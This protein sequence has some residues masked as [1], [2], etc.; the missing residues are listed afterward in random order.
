MKSDRFGSA[1]GEVWHLFLK[2]KKETDPLFVENIGETFP[3]NRIFLKRENHPIFVIEYIVS[4][5]EHLEVDGVKY[6]LEEG[7]LCILEPKVPHSYRSDTSYP[8]HKKW[9]NFTSD[10][11]E[12]LYEK[13]GLKGTIVYKDTN[14]GNFFD[15]LLAIA[16]TS[17]HSEDICHDVALNLFNLLFLLA[18][19]IQKKGEKRVSKLAL[20]TKEQLDK[21]IYTN[22]TLD[23]I[24]QDI[25]YS[26]KQ[27]TREF[28][29]YYNDTPYNYLISTKI[30]MAKRLLKTS[31]LSIKEISIKLGFENQHYFSN[32][33]KKK[34]K[35][36]PSQYRDKYLM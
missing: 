28:K 27:I 2:S 36:S 1:Y 14:S 16:K 5:I 24:L 11:F 7:D 8:V 22:A 30:S 4:G 3:D 19:S 21:N 31:S 13:M 23:E 20:K 25:F 18:K 6:K 34:T 29:K 15:V 17:L 9:I 10:I 12:T 35:L 26:K 33:F 32:A